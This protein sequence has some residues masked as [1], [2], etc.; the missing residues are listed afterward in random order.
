MKS[1]ELIRTFPE[2]KETRIEFAQDVI[3]YV[4]SGEVNPLEIEVFLKCLEDTINFI[5][6]DIR[7]K[8]CIIDEVDKYEERFDYRGAIIE[9]RHKTTYNYSEDSKHKELKKL[10]K[11]RET[12]L[13]AI[14]EAGTV[15]PDTGE[16]IYRPSKKVSDYIVIEFK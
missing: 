10:I 8:S 14:P 2:T 12:F 9:K 15:D 3:K 6:K 11:E 5:R 13:K 16:M 1:L 7:Y 4:L